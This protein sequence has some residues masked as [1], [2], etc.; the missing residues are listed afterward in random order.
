MSRA[1][2]NGAALTYTITV[3][4]RIRLLYVTGTLPGRGRTG[5]TRHPIRH[6]RPT[7]FV[8]EHSHKCGTCRRISAYMPCRAY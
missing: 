8:A 2:V 6:R 3:S 5:T 7:L 4:C 1:T